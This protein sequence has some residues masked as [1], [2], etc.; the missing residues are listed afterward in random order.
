MSQVTK[1][2]KGPMINNLILDKD[3]SKETAKGRG[4]IKNKLSANS[5]NS[6]AI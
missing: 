3:H 6:A 5:D 1:P 2:I 4:H